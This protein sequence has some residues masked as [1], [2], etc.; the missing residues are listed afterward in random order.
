M[1]LELAVLLLCIRRGW[2]WHAVGIIFVVWFMWSLTEPDVRH[3]YYRLGRIILDEC[4][5][6]IEWVYYQ[7]KRELDQYLE[8]RVI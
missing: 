1:L 3:V 7:L 2:A 8:I 4:R 5:M 6:M